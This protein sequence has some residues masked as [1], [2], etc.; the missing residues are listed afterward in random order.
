MHH[1]II[2]IAFIFHGTHGVVKFHI[3]ASDAERASR[4]GFDAARSVGCLYREHA[5]HCIAFSSV[6]VK[7]IE[8]K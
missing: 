1:F 5:S 4:Q 7:V 6:G 3:D 2:A 8:V